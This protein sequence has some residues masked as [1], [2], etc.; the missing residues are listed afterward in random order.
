[1][2]AALLV[3]APHPLRV[4]GRGFAPGERIAVTITPSAGEPVTGHAT[5]DADG[6]FAADFPGVDADGGLEGVAAGSAGG[7]ASFQ[8]AT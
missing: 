3:A 1:M 8:F 5:A 4:A 2:P 7:H 6:T